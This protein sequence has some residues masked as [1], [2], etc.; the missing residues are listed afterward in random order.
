MSAG[1]GYIHDDTLFGRMLWNQNFQYEHT[2]GEVQCM[3]DHYLDSLKLLSV[4][5]SSNRTRSITS[6]D[7]NTNRWHTYSRNPG[8]RYKHVKSSDPAVNAVF[9]IPDAH[10]NYHKMDTRA[11]LWS[12][13][14]HY[15]PDI[16]SYFTRKPC[17]AHIVIFPHPA[18]RHCRHPQGQVP[19]VAAAC[20]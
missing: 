5:P 20:S 10:T 2:T 15:T 14:P 16:A 12:E 4:L 17:S 19:I 9:P 18:S 7:N 6:W 1:C 8:D 13:R 3:T 11:L